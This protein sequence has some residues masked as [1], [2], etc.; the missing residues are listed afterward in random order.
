[1][2]IANNDITGFVLA[3]GKS[4]RMGYDKGL[5]NVG[6]STLIQSAVNLM[7]AFTTNVYILA[8]TEKYKNIGVPCIADKIDSRGP[9]SALY[10]GLISSRTQINIFLA[11]DMPKMRLEFI[12]YLVKKSSQHDAVLMKFT[13][14]NV[15]PLCGIYKKSCL[16]IIKSNFEHNQYKLSELLA[17]LNVAYISEKNLNYLGLDRSI[18]TNINTPEDLKSLSP[19]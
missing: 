5:I 12:R 2:D 16:T 18:F 13:D 9:L 10:T 17:E 6:E 1:M 14:G 11:C 7:K 15:E 4:S 8:P 3:G 19:K